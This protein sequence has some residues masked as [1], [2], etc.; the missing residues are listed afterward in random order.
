[1]YSKFLES[2]DLHFFQILRKIWILANRFK[3]A[4]QWYPIASWLGE[5]KPKVSGAGGG[6]SGGENGGGGKDTQKK[7]NF[8]CSDFDF[9]W[10]KTKFFLNY[11]H[12]LWYC[13]VSSKNF[14]HKINHFLKTKNLKNQKIIFHRF[15]NM[16]HLFGPKTKIGHF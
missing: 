11:G 1:M 4:N 16:S 3:N 7:L 2:W 8:F 12:L 6:A 14:R 5:F 9:N 10:R 13:G 15:Q